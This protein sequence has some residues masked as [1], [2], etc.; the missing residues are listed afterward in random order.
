MKASQH[1]SSADLIG[2]NSCGSPGSLPAC[3]PSA[4]FVT[5]CYH[6]NLPTRP[7]GIFLASQRNADV[8]LRPACNAPAHVTPA[9]ARC[10]GSAYECAC[11]VKIGTSRRTSARHT[12]L[13]PGVADEL[14]RLGAQGRFFFLILSYC[15]LFKSYC[16]PPCTPVY[17]LL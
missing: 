14:T 13:V 6:G 4:P 11:S 9:S 2:T 15:H 8:S 7:K 12:W 3:P 1:K 17:A 5:R 10:S 16:C